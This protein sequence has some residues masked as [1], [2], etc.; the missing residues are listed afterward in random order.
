MLGERVRL[1]PDHHL[2]GPPAAPGARAR[3]P[4]EAV[5]TKVSQ[6][7][8]KRPPGDIKYREV[9]CHVLLL[10]RDGARARWFLSIRCVP[11]AAP[12]L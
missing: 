10:S 12:T 4:R 1:P 6:C 7:N 3:P 9:D 8:A 2:N 5:I 11:D